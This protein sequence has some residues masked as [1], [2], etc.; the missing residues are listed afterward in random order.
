LPRDGYMKNIDTFKGGITMLH[1][2]QI[3]YDH[4]LHPLLGISAVTMTE[5]QDKSIIKEIYGHRKKP[6]DAFGQLLTYLG[7]RSE[8]KNK[9]RTLTFDPEGWNRMGYRLVKGGDMLGGKP[10]VVFI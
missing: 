7:M 1:D 5:E 8:I 2:A 3:T 4:I 6:R 9:M 10:T